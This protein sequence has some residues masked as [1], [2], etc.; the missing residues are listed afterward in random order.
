MSYTEILVALIAVLAGFALVSMFSDLWH[1]RPPDPPGL[2]TSARTAGAKVRVEPPVDRDP[3]PAYPAEAG[4][5]GV[6]GIR[7]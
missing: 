5:A 3:A 2:S 4:S 6:T 1:K 7:R